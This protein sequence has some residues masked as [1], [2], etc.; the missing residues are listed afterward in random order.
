MTSRVASVPTALL[1]LAALVAGCDSEPNPEDAGKNP[2]ATAAALAEGLAGG[3]LSGLDDGVLDVPSADAAAELDEV[4]SGLGEVTPSVQLGEVTEDGDSAIAVLTWT[5]PLTPANAWTYDAP[6]ALTRTDGEWSVTWDRTVIEPSL[7]PAATLDRTTIEP[8]RGDI[9]GAG[10]VALVTYRDVVR[11]GIDRSGLAKGPAARSARALAA[12][13]GGV[14]AG[15]FAS[16]V[17]DAGDRAFVEAIVLRADDVPLRVLRGYEQIDGARL[18]TDSIPLAP[19]STF[20]APILGRVGEVTAEMVEDDPE[21]YQ[22]GDIA[23]ISGLQQ[24][25]DEQLQGTPGV[26]VQAVGSDGKER[27][28]FRV[29]GT[30]G[31]NLRTTLDE[32]LQRLA[33]SLL[34]DVSAASAVVA[35]RPSNGAILAAANGPGNGG[36]NLATFGQYAPG[37]TFKTVSGLALLR[38]GLAPAGRVTCPSSVDVDGRDFENYDDYPASATGSITFAQAFANSC[39]T[40]FIGERDRLGRRDLAAAAASLGLGIDHDLGFPAYFGQVPPAES[41]TGAAADMIGQGTVL[42]SP[43]AMAAVAASVQ[44]GATVVPRLLEEI[45]VAPSSDAEPLTTAEARQ[46]R[47]L[48]RGVVTSG[49]GRLL[50]DVPG[51]PV[52]AKTGT[53]EYET[54]GQIRTHAWMIAAQGDLAVAVFVGDG[55]SGSGT[56]GPILEA[57]LRGVS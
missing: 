4:T 51:K 22:P 35:I 48:M 34:D 12:L 36:Q 50:A 39:N 11:V 33:E 32:R 55:A 13:V 42:A 24:R 9:R 19:T 23:G 31:K 18:V 43:M 37:S 17:R 5:W 49:S 41:A 25:Y 29:D 38:S 30:R 3:D 8:R 2:G 27:D 7:T 44:E 56:A 6:I 20:A 16:R 26:V 10:G 54:D 28:L 1:V 14:D 45:D 47:E 53:A 15:A 21:R 40:A 46:L 52:I 57:F